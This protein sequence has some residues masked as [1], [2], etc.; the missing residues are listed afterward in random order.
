MLGV[1]KWRNGTFE[2]AQR[3]WVQWPALTPS[4]PPAAEL[5]PALQ[6]RTT[7]SL[8]LAA[9]ALA[10]RTTPGLAALGHSEVVICT[11]SGRC[12]LVVGMGNDLSTRSSILVRRRLCRLCN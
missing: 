1:W 7:S 9:A 2:H 10:Q 8:A 12:G 11:S 3:V 4:L 5:F 6:S